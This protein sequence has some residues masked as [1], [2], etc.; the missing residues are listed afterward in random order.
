MTLKHAALAL[1][2]A[3]TAAVAHA[4]VKASAVHPGTLVLSGGRNIHAV[5]PGGRDDRQLQAGRLRQEVLT[6]SAVCGISRSRAT[7]LR[8]FIWN[9]CRWGRR[10]AN[11]GWFRVG[12][13]P[14]CSANGIRAATAWPG[15][16]RSDSGNRRE[17]HRTDQGTRGWARVGLRAGQ[18]GAHDP[19]DERCIQ[20]GF[21]RLAWNGRPCAAIRCRRWCLR[22]RGNQGRNPRLLK[23][24]QFAR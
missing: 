16:I 2:L 22:Q 7:P 13:D 21:T 12:E 20:T 3:G 1:A 11:A 5:E 24:S 19:T 10:C 8:S 17:Q 18:I 15:L 14:F 6:Y 9:L 23:R 4:G